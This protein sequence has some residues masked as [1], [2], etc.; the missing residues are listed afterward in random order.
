MPVNPRF[1]LVTGAGSG[2]GRAS[3]LALHAAGYA[4]A[5][6]G[7]RAAELEKTTAMAE[8]GAAMLP[9]AADVSKPE[10]VTALFARVKQEFGRLDVHGFTQAHRKLTGYGKCP[11]RQLRDYCCFYPGTVEML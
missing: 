3:A 10:A 5:L 7:R 8:S 9:V 2:I 6:A 1:A 11:Q 4:V